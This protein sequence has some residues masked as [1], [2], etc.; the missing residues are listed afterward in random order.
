MTTGDSNGAAQETIARL[1]WQAASLAPVTIESCREKIDGFV[2][3]LTASNGKQLVV[4]QYKPFPNEPRPAVESA[5]TEAVVLRRLGDSL[6]SGDEAVRFGVPR[7][8]LFDEENAAV[9]M[10]R[11]D[12]Q[13][14]DGIVVNARNHR[15]PSLAA[16][17]LR[18]AGAWLRAMQKATPSDADAGAILSRLIATA[19]RD[20]EIAAQS[21]ASIR[22]N[23]GAIESTLRTLAADASDEWL[24]A[25]GCHGDLWPGNIFI[26]EGIVQAIDFEGFHDGLP[27]EDV[28]YFLIH[29]EMYFKFPLV[30]K[31]FAPFARSFM[32]GYADVNRKALRRMFIIKGLQVLARGGGAMKHLS[33]REW[34]IHLTVRAR[35]LRSVSGD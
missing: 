22:R 24:K 2:A 27:L 26:G 33:I 8:V 13:P 4:K 31:Q 34:L 14:L 7:V 1:N 28:A 25:V 18:H 30:R 35:V 5:R 10:E 17:P 11:A 32:R 20:L 21:D 16:V 3:E 6:P 19:L 23:R 9:V 15:D 29:L 12:G